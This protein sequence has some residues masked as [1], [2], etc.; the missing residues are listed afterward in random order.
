MALVVEDGTGKADAESYTSVAAFKAWADAW[1]VSYAAYA[2]SAIEQSARRSTR[3]ID[4]KFRNRFPGTKVKGRSQALEW[5]RYVAPSVD[6]TTEDLPLS[7]WL[8]NLLTITSTEVPV[9]I[10][11]ATHHAMK[12]DLVSPG[13]LSPDV[14]PG[15]IKT[16]VAV[17][18]AISVKYGTAASAVDTMRP[19]VTDIEEVLAPII[20]PKN[21]FSGSVARG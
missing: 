19:I 3:Y 16:E 13:A 11:E 15:K 20:Y 2:D 21:C 1:G 12:R 9:E 10:I 8:T 14:T 6:Q 18:G 7:D 17:E 4:G 5:P